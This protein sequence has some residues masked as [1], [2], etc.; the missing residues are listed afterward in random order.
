MSES[1]GVSVDPA[2]PTP[3]YEQVRRGLAAAI[4]RG[5]LSPGDRL[6]SV[7]QLAGDLRLA[8]GTVA[9][10]YSLLEES[11][12]VVSRR[13]AGTRVS[14]DLPPTDPVDVT[15]LAR[16]YLAGAARAGVSGPDALRAVQRLV[17]G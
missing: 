10:A 7:R 8:P 1:D 9:R 16:D 5:A 3:P 13:G 12:L 2:D 17:E 4:G 6:P 14:S 11:G 15:A